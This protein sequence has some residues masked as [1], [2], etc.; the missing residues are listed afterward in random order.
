VLVNSR[1][2]SATRLHADVRF[3]TRCSG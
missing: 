3:A 2:D 1:Y